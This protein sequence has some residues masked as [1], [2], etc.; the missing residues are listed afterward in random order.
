MEKEKYLCPCCQADISDYVHKQIVRHNHQKSMT[1]T[2]RK[3]TKRKRE[4]LNKAGAERLV[5]W[6]KDHP[7]E[8]NRQRL[9]A[10]RCRTADSFARQAKTVRETAKKKTLKFA[11]LVFE[12]RNAGRGITP[13]VEIE[14]MEKARQI[15]RE[16]N[17]AERKARRKA[18]AKK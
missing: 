15:V 1:S 6:M 7:E 8:S 13:E 12:A 9:A 10:Q 16:E 4:E 11:E 18:A 17:R 3:I 5:K 14:L 2:N